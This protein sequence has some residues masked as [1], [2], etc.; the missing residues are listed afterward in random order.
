VKPA[1]KPVPDFDDIELEVKTDPEAQARPPP[2]PPQRTPE[3]LLP[4]SESGQHMMLGA[5]K[6]GFRDPFEGM[7]MGAPGT[8]AIELATQPKR[9][10][11]AEA[12]RAEAAERAKATERAPASERAED[13]AASAPQEEA[14]SG[15]GLVSSVLTGLLGAA[16]AIAVVFVSALESDAAAGWLGLGPASDVVATR[17]VSGIYDTAGGKQVFYV[18]GRIENHGAKA[19]GPVHVTAELLADGAPDGRA[20]A[21]VGAEPSPEDVWS[22]KST[23][24]AEKLVRSLETIPIDRKLQP[25]ASVPF[26]VVMTEP[27]PDLQNRRLRV[28]VES[29]DAWV[30]QAKGKAR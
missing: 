19:R 12:V 1:V 8:G 28:R 5:V 7:D 17:V 20:E 9:D 10:K 22:L 11:L 6:V 18:R 27:P 15:R 3:S 4:P 21:I 25:G 26:F 13:Q 24:D 14:Q 23:A 2:K 16:V 30:P 29:S